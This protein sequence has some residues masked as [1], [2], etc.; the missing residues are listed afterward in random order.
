MQDQ[1]AL[2]EFRAEARDHLAR[3]SEGL[4]R[5]ERLEGVARVEEVNRL[6]RSLH[7][8]KGGAGF[9]GLKVLESVSHGAETVLDR[10]RKGS[11]AVTPAVIDIL[12][13]ATDLLG[14]LLEQ[15]ESG[16]EKN[17]AGLVARL[18]DAASGSVAPETMIA[19]DPEPLAG[20]SDSE[21][22]PHPDMGADKNR[23]IRVSVE[24]ADRL[25]A[26]ASEL[27]LV[28]NQAL[29]K[30][31]P[32]DSAERELVSRLNTVASDIQ[33][34]V[35]STRMQPVA[36]LFQRLPRVAR[37][38]ARQLGKSIEL[39]VSGAE[40][41]LDRG[42]IERLADPLTHLIRNACDHGIEPGPERVRAGKPETGSIRVEARHEGGQIHVVVR[43]DGAGIDPERVGRLAIERGLATRAEVE[44]MSP[45]QRQLLVLRPGF[46]TASRVTDLSGRGVGLDVVQANLAAIG[47]TLQ[48]VSEPGLGTG[49]HLRL[50]LTLA[51]IPCLVVEAGGFR[52]CVPQ[53]DL[54]ELVLLAEGVRQGVE[55]SHGGL[56]YRLRDQLLPVVPLA[57]LLGAKTNDP[58]HCR[59]L[60]VVRCGPGRLGLV[61]DKVSSPEEIVVKPLH[62]ALE[63][64]GLFSGATVLGD[65]LVSLI[66]DTEGVA[67]KSGAVPV[68]AASARVARPAGDGG[69]VL[70]FED[71][72]G[73][74][75]GTPLKTISKVVRYEAG[76]SRRLA[77]R[78]TL[79]IPGG[80]RAMVAMHELVPGA[81]RG[82]IPESGYLLL[83]NGDGTPGVG[84]AVADIVDTA[85]APAALQP[86][87]LAAAGVLGA[88]RLNGRPTLVVDTAAMAAAWG[89]AG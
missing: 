3:V 83:P 61:I 18:L 30:F 52:V 8:I 26:L 37:D 56:V 22:A 78:A 87:P 11:L 64:V 82:I 85:R 34:S 4:V 65:G 49:F 29:N 60:A 81:P 17:A 45:G 27:V 77:G 25:M 59:Y 72:S 73:G 15:A 6:F 89:G 84:V 9:L 69:L 42:V 33:R 19:G 38:L 88:A 20:E 28:R 86:A 70:L 48:L 40:V 1:A 54:E 80:I 63:P 39:S 75:Y 71:S 44:S 53:R 7:S 55:P 76:Q 23:S 36:S 46:S 2:D 14:R 24:V 68:P 50:P 12:L 10:V 13:E 5:L 21:A 43:D 58:G 41:E 66:L 79:D 67:N 51:I 47:G 32:R 74:R 35:T 31:E 16:G 57:G 62:P